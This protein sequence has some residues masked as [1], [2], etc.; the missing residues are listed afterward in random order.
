MAITEKEVMRRKTDDYGLL[1]GGDLIIRCKGC[2]RIIYEG[3]L[4]NQEH[5]C[6]FCE[7]EPPPK[8]KK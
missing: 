2:G 5:K 3:P 1:I 8:E 4:V 6:P 7:A